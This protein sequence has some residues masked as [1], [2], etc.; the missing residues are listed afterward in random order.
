M[1]S[2]ELGQN[3]VNRAEEKLDKL[4]FSGRKASSSAMIWLSRCRS[5]SRSLWPFPKNPIKSL[6][7]AFATR[8]ASQEAAAGAIGEKTDFIFLCYPQEFQLFFPSIPQVSFGFSSEI[9][10]IAEEEEKEDGHTHKSEPPLLECN[11]AI[12]KGMRKKWT[13]ILGWLY[14]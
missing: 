13:R 3:K 12:Q 10:P 11:W 6:W 1:I 2:L 9:A 5:S 8:F 14:F 4:F 7:L